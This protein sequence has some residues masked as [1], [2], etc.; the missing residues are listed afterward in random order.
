MVTAPEFA[1][2][3]IGKS[4]DPDKLVAARDAGEFEPDEPL[5]LRLPSPKRLS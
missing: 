4:Y 1:P 3:R 5:D 2:D